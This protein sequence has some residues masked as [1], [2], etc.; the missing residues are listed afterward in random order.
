[1]GTGPEHYAEAERLI[2]DSINPHT[3]GPY[4][5]DPVGC[6]R[7]SL[8]AAQ[9]HATLA[10]TAATAPITHRNVVDQTAA[11]AEVIGAAPP[12]IRLTWWLDDGQEN[13]GKP[14]L[15]TTY[16]TACQAG[17]ERYKADNP[18][19]DLITRTDAL[20]WLD[21]EDADDD[22][23]ED[24]ELAVNGRRTGIFVRPIRPKDEA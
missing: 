10:L 11:W 14:P 7:N 13:P 6:I 24:V 23:R 4:D 15:Y 16:E 5:D 21:V 2:A 20:C 9:A 18:F 19:A 12:R 3:G 17:A 22:A 8:L 1:M